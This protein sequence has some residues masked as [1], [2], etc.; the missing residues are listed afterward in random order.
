MGREIV[1]TLPKGSL[2]LWKGTVKAGTRKV[3]INR[4]LTMPQIW[5]RED[6]NAKRS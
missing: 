2:A 5:K 6:T 4:F 1:A 3:Y